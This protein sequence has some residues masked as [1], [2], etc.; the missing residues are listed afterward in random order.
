MART[1]TPPSSEPRPTT[2]QMRLPKQPPQK[3]LPPKYN[4]SDP[5]SITYQELLKQKP[6]RKKP[7]GSS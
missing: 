6:R 1:K 5:N 7:R 2:G 3:K 4:A